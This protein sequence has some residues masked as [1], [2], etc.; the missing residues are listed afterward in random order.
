MLNQAGYSLGQS[1]CLLSGK[2]FILLFFLII[3]HYSLLIDNCSAQFPLRYYWQ[4]LSTPVTYNL[5]SIILTN[6]G[7]DY[8]LGD[9]GTQLYSTNG[10]IIFQSLAGLPNINFYC[11]DRSNFGYTIVGQ[12]GSI[13]YKQGELPGTW[14]LEPTG[15]TST[16][17]NISNTRI[18]NSPYML[19]RIAVGENGN[20]LK[21]TWNQGTN[22]SV[23][24]QIT[25]VSS[26]NLYSVTFSV[27]NPALTGWIAGNNGTL[28]KT[29]D[30]GDNWNIVN[31]GVTNKLNNIRF[32]DTTLGW[33]MGSNGLILRTTNGGLNW[34]S[35]NSGTTADLKSIIKS[36]SETYLYGTKYFACGSNGIIIS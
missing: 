22:W 15:I 27:S 25:T 32:E 35:L 8:I 34:V 28:L 10:G 18:S 7:Y 3:I 24:T 31:L 36:N 21:S 5:N 33:I 6:Y 12:N 9:N 20:I 17:F 1:R 26:Q 30:G 11:I 29:S 23:W 2:K 14:T 13:Y 4:N 19:R 16:L